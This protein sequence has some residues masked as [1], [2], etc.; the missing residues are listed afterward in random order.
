[1]VKTSGRD[2]SLAKSSAF[3]VDPSVSA[4]L[5][6]PVLTVIVPVGFVEPV[7]RQILSVRIDD[8]LHLGGRQ[9]FERAFDCREVCTNR[10]RRRE[11]P[12][13]SALCQARLRRPAGE[14]E[15]IDLVAIEDENPAIAQRERVLVERGVEE[16]RDEEH[17]LLIGEAGVEVG[18]GRRLLADLEVLEVLLTLRPEGDLEAR[19]L[20]SV[21]LQIRRVLVDHTVDFERG[22]AA[23]DRREL[24]RI[25][26]RFHRLDDLPLAVGLLQACRLSVGALDLHFLDVVRLQRAERLLLDRAPARLLFRIDEVDVA[27]QSREDDDESE[28]G[29]TAHASASA[30]R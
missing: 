19:G 23:R 30:T 29:P 6:L 16:R 25:R 12:I 21:L 20:E 15:S 9:A 5:E 2:A 11:S 10:D 17:P 14:L 3:S 26:V 1:M 22:D 18:A 13:G 8:A 27:D 7:L 24:A 4:A 28:C